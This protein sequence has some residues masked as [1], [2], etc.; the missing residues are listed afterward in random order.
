MTD[1]ETLREQIPPQTDIEDFIDQ[2]CE[3]HPDTQYHLDNLKDEAMKFFGISPQAA[4][5][6]LEDYGH[7]GHGNDGTFLDSMVGWAAYYVECRKTTKKVGPNT[8]AHHTNKSAVYV[9][10]GED[11]RRRNWLVNNEIV[12]SVKI[13]KT[14]PEYQD[15]DTLVLYLSDKWP[16]E[17]VDQAV[18]AVEKKA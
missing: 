1:F 6:K 7:T 13:L 18:R 8:W 5:L 9:P 10:K 15:R 17:L 12:P 11:A 16:I 3:E 4:D 2:L 14:L